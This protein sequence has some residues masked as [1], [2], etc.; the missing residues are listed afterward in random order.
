MN[1]TPQSLLEAVRFFSKGVIT[2][3]VVVDVSKEIHASG[4]LT[5]S[6]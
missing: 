1:D 3:G 5:P 6:F 4:P 2:T